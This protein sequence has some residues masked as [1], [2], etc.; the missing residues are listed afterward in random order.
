MPYRALHQKRPVIILKISG[1][2]NALSYFCALHSLI[3]LPLTLFLSFLF[4]KDGSTL[5]R[6]EGFLSS[7]NRLSHPLEVLSVSSS[8]RPVLP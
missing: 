5:L 4:F 6:C 1:E 7:S 8:H 2:G 3:H